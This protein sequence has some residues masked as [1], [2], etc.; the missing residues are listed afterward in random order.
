MIKRLYKQVIE[1][2]WILLLILL[3]IT[4]MPLV[5]RVLG[6]DTVAAPSIVLLALLIILWFIPYLLKNGKLPIHAL[7]L[8][9]FLICA[10]LSTFLGFFIEL[11]PFKDFSFLKGNIQAIITLVIGVGFYLVAACWPGND[12]SLTKALRLINWGGVVLLLWSSAQAISWFG[13]HRYPTWMFDL[14]GLISARVLYHHRVTGL[15]LEPSWLAHQLN[16]LYLPLWLAASVKKYSSHSFRFLGFSLENILL[17]LGITA[18]FL[19]FSRIGF[20]AF[21][22]MTLT[23]VIQLNIKFVNL[24]KMK[25]LAQARVAQN[26]ISKL[27]KTISIILSISLVVLYL[28]VL[29]AGLFILTKIDSR[30]AYL[31]DFSTKKDNPLLR[32][33]TNLQFG[34]RAVYWMAGW[35]IFNIFPLLGIGLG[36]AGFYFP[37]LIT[38]YG[39]TLIEV[40]R[41]VYRSHVLLNIKNLWVRLLAETGIVGFSIF[42]SWMIFLF[43]TA[44]RNLNKQPKLV[45]VMGW[46]GLFVLIALLVEG[47]SIDSFALP[48]WWISLGLMTSTH[49]FTA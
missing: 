34:E 48:Y 40:R 22:L 9:F 28:I 4:S 11:P 3:P 15:A 18:L 39:W 16:M 6:S 27:S 1:A 45:S 7:P 30:M 19:T 42:I 44:I 43:I 23:L 24:V 10:L 5:A 31:F 26:K 17:L 38:P 12:K 25:F 36:N 41:L 49:R 29:L 20:L 47:F 46:A 33:F 2:F 14:Q 21:L 37:Q 35:E 8:I 13:F 32:Y